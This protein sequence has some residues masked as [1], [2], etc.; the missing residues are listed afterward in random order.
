LSSQLNYEALRLGKWNLKVLPDE[1]SGTLP[2]LVLSAVERQTPNKH[3]QT[4]RIEWSGRNKT[5]ALFLK[6]FHG[7]A[8]AGAFKD[9][10]RESKAFR[11]LRQSRA[12]AEAGFP[13]T[14]AVAAGEERNRRLLKRAFLLTVGI[15]GEP[16]PIFLRNRYSCGPAGLALT[17]KRAGLEALG[18]QIRRF[19]E[20]GYVHGDLVASNILIARTP[21]GSLEFYLMD[22]DRTRRYPRWLAQ[23]LWKRN[24]VQLNRIPLPGISLQ[25]RLR[26]FRA[27]RGQ[28]VWNRADRALLRW[29]EAKTRKRRKEC[30]AVDPAGSFRR[31]MSWRTV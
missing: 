3:P 13:V 12:L 4:V 29:I 6:I 27:Y 10:F 15:K 28:H 5:E 22:N 7:S 11:S 21:S 31:L 16:A 23:S 30:D 19:H 2:Q 24:L 9:W 20:L 14:T 17:S 26:F 18:R 25:D 1:W 8:G